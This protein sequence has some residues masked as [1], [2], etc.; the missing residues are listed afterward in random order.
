M[1]VVGRE[2]QQGVAIVVAEVG[3]QALGQQRCEHRRVATTGHVEDLLGKF[4]GF[5]IGHLFRLV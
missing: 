1:T 3:G 5:V 2:H 4:G